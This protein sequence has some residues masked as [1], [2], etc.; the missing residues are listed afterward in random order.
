M[1]NALDFSEKREVLVVDDTPENLR[2]MSWVLQPHYKVKLAPS[3][4]RALQI[5]FSGEPP[6]LILL[7]IMMPEIDG[8]EVLRRLQ[9]APETE[10]IPV[11]FVTAKAEEEDEKIGLD[12]GA[13]D[14]ITKP[15]SPPIV[16]ARVR[17]HLLLKEARDFLKEQK[18]YLQGQ[19]GGA[20]MVAIEAFASL[21]QMR[22]DETPNH[23]QRMQQF[24]RALAGELRDH[25]RFASSL[26]D[27]DISLMVD[28]AAL[29]DIG[30]VGMPDNV[31]FATSHVDG[32]VDDAMMAHPTIGRDAIARVQRRAGA[33]A[34]FLRTAQE[35]VYSHHERW[36]GSG[37]PQGL[38]GDEI[39]V[40]A[41]LVALADV[42]DA[43][44][45]QRP[46]RPAGTHDEAVEIIG[47][48]KGTHFDPDVVDAFLRT[49][50]AFRAIASRLLDTESAVN[51][52]ATRGRP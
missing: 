32:D 11:I 34:S 35:I 40:A 44:T 50:R 13:V 28:S 29:H 26:S 2:V 18:R 36:D 30:K 25:P 8:Y 3:G 5:C 43:L 14:Y 19:L 47:T 4:G 12:L 51:E 9:A 15:I 42:Y 20:Q 1:A 46:H 37:Y 7:D 21:A 31:L 38:R 16:L 39:P 23:I 22:D 33:D 49:Q 6:D 17:T 52:H 41:R 27:E 48:A 24:V 45:S 10:G